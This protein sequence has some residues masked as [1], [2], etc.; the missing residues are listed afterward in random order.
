MALPSISPYPMPAEF[1]LPKNKVSWTPDPKRAALLIHDMQQYFLDAFTAGK[2]PVVEL[3]SNIR[4]LRSRCAELGIPVIYSAQPGGQTPERRGLLRDFWGPGM[5]DGPYQKKIVD[6]L[7][8]DEHDIVITKWRYSAFQKTDL[9]E[10]LRQ[11]DRDQLIVCGVYAH[12]GCLLTACDAFMQDVQPFFVADA[13]A[14]FSWECHRMALTYAAER[15]AVTTTTRRLLD[16]LGRMQNETREAQAAADGQ[17]ITLQLVREQ[18]ARLLD[19]SPSNLADSDDLISR[20]LDSVRIMSLVERWRRIGV[21]V[22]FVELA[23]HPTLADWWRLLSS[24]S[25]RVSSTSTPD[26]LSL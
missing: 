6:E 13:V 18:V 1:D 26:N 25:K 19:E 23:E 16:E 22:T 14:D 8:P 24:R 9:L 4:L 5:D 7:A 3:L 17:P 21:E 15:C 2:S 12:I 10:I 11:R 20:G